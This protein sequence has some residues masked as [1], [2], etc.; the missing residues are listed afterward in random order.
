M[1]GPLR[2][3]DSELPNVDLWNSNS[4]F[5]LVS[6]TRYQI[7]II[8]FTSH[9]FFTYTTMSNSIENTENRIQ[10]AVKAYHQSTKPNIAGSRSRSRDMR[11]PLRY[12]MLRYAQQSC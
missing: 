6:P 10:D 12:W 2:D 5:V 9:Q 1:E 3:P 4:F 8:V 11:T 7:F